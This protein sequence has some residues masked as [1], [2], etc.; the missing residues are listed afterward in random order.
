MNI[1]VLKEKYRKMSIPVKASIW[2]MVCNVIN[3]GISLLS[4]PIFTRLLTEEQYGTFAIFQSWFSIL[5]IFTSLNVFLGGYQKGLLLFKEDIKRF[6]ASQLGLTTTITIIFFG[7]YIL[8]KNFWTGIF[9]LP[10]NLMTAMFIELLLMPALELWSTQQRFDYKYRKYVALTLAMSIIAVGGGAIAVI[11]SKYK[12][13]ARVYTDVLAKSLFAGLLFVLIFLSG[14]CFFEKKYW[15]YSLLFNLPLIPHYLSNYVLNQSDRVMIGKM[16][17]NT[18]AAYYSVAYTISTMMILITNAVN[19]SLTPYIYKSIE[20][21]ERKKIK[22]VTKPIL[23]L[24]AVLCLITMA[25]AP[26]VIR[27]FAGK[28]YL[29]AI[30]VI[31]PIAASVFFIF[32]YS[33][34]SNVEYYYQKTGFIAVATC[35]SA[36]LNLLLNYV[37]I[38]KYGYYA[39]GYT[40]LVCYICLAVF[41]YIFYRKVMKLQNIKEEIYDKR[42]ILLLSVIVIFVMII[43]VV[44]YRT[45][46]IRYGILTAILV[47]AYLFRNKIKEIILK[48]K[49]VKK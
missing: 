47:I 41:H 27:V 35:L 7:I 9:D 29:D 12:L 5:I 11:C 36:V 4:T 24:I 14:K 49:N 19:N 25:F 1:T 2:Y 3:K 20:S 44:T 18:Q 26:E 10:S 17:G 45:I 37:F 34:F 33:L 16:V 13:E 43:M 22:K 38:K 46:V 15:K 42:L 48:F 23:F 40:T 6:T 32:L 28:Q 39:A 8:N 21:D 30:Y 31:P